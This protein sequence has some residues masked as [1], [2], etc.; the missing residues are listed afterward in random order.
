M[1]LHCKYRVSMSLCVQRQG[2]GFITIHVQPFM[3][4]FILCLVSL[5]SWPLHHQWKWCSFVMHWSLHV[6]LVAHT[7]SYSDKSMATSVTPGGTPRGGRGHS[8]LKAWVPVVKHTVNSKWNLSQCWSI[9]NSSSFERT[10]ASW[11]V[12]Y[13]GPITVICL[14]QQLLSR[15]VYPA[16]LIRCLSLT[17]S[18]IRGQSPAEGQMVSF[19]PL[20]LSLLMCRSVAAFHFAAFSLEISKMPIK[21]IIE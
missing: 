14:L 9:N 21:L 19:L 4:D 20:G 10:S 2:C 1:K 15:T 8:T 7:V 16:A 11:K 13:R 6:A 18:S 12:A 5:A 17:P 3:L